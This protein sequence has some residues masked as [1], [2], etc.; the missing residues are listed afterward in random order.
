MNGERTVSVR[1]IYKGSIIKLDVHD[2]ILENQKSATREIITHNGGVG[3]L[4]IA[5]DGKVILVKQFR[6]PFECFTV[7]IPAGKREKEEAP[8]KC[9]MRELAEETGIKAGKLSFLVEMLPSPGYTSE[10]VYIY[11]AEDLTFGEASTD[12]DEFIE[13][14]E[15]QLDEAYDLI[16]KGEIKDAKTVIAIT[17]AVN[18]RLIRKF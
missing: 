4:P 1:N 16:K 17:M 18:E 3:V 12:E 2:V 5:K 6:K 10:T 8:E 11:L 15:L 13:V 9:A 7:E 14:F